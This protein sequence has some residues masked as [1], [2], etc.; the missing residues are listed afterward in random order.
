MFEEVSVEFGRTKSPPAAQNFK[1]ALKPGLEM[2]FVDPL[3]N[4]C[5]SASDIVGEF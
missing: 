5:S 1:T 2:L 4:K 3:Y